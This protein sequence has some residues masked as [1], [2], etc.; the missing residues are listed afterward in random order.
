MAGAGVKKGFEYGET[1]EFS[2]NVSKNPVSINSFNATILKL[3]G[4]NHQ[5]LSY[6][7]NGL[8]E[9]LTGVEEVNY[10]KDIMT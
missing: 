6:F 2:Y 7:H 1:D 5:K 4:I 9:K 10:I 8:E 3:M